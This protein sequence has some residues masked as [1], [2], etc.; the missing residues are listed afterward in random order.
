MIQ[1][2]IYNCVDQLLIKKMEICQSQ[3]KN[4]NMVRID[5]Q[6]AFDSVTDGWILKV[7]NILKSSKVI[8]TF[9]KYK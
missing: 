7:L 9:L 5:Y 3:K 1:K 4:L 2:E 8:I 6:K